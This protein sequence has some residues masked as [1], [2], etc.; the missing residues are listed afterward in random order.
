MTWRYCHTPDDR[1]KLLSC[2]LWVMR[3]T[4]TTVMVAGDSVRPQTA[5]L[6]M[7]SYRHGV[8]LL[9]TVHYIVTTNCQQKVP[10]GLN[11]GL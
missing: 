11:D 10:C 8:A 5:T 9:R 7:P 2:I 6:T 4:L 3:A 1:Q